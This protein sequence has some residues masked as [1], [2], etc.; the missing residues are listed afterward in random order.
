[1]KKVESQCGMIDGTT[2]ILTYKDNLFV[3]RSFVVNQAS[4]IGMLQWNKSFGNTFKDSGDDEGDVFGQP[5]GSG[6][7]IDLDLFITAGHC[8]S[9]KLPGTYPPKKNKRDLSPTEMAPLMNVVFNFESISVNNDLVSDSVSF[10]VVSLVDLG[11]KLDYAI[12]RLGPRNGK[13]AGELFGWLKTVSSD[14]INHTDTLCIIQHPQGK[15]KRVE[16]GPLLKYDDSFLYY[17]KI[18][19]YGGSSGAPVINYSSGLLEGVHFDGDCF[20]E[21]GTV[22]GSNKAV[23]IQAIKKVSHVLKD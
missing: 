14:Y 17:N 3:P 13:K 10:P 20:T 15:A 6:C 2:D 19:T 16:C 21:Q 5:R 23:R 7:L 9:S 1:M 11:D 8:F 12:V 4:P 18:D 22:I